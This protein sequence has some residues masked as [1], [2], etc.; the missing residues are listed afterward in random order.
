MQN[1]ACK[2]NASSW[3]PF[4]NYIVKKNYYA[5]SFLPCALVTE[6]L[7]VFLYDPETQVKEKN[8]SSF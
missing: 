5:T 8:G 1:I 4:S 2:I 7:V 6:N 3:L